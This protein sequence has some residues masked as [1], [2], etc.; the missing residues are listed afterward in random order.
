MLP[1]V[2]PQAM[3]T[4]LPIVATKADGS[5]EAVEDG[6][7]GFLVEPQRPDQVADRLLQLIDSPEKRTAFG[8]AGKARVPMFGAKK[9]AADIDQLYKSL[10]K[11]KK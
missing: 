11:R 10:I 9:M 6:V 4:A 1:R 7:N 3:A 5:A 2:L 8:A